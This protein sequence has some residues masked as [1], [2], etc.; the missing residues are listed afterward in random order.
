VRTYN[1]KDGRVKDHRTNLQINDLSGMM[2][3][4]ESLQEMIDALVLEEKQNMMLAFQ[5]KK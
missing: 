1:Y 5:D 4:N 2:E 3:G